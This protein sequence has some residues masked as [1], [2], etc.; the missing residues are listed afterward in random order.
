MRASL[1]SRVA[2]EEE[3]LDSEQQQ[4]APVIVFLLGKI[5]TEGTDRARGH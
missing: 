5:A 4:E 2:S 3:V 1:P